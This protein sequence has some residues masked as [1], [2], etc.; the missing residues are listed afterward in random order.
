M[1]SILLTGLMA[2]FCGAAASLSAQVAG[3][4][5]EIEVLILENFE[6]GQM[7]FIREGGYVQ[8]ALW[9]DPKRK[10]KGALQHIEADRMVVNDVPVLFAECK[11]IKGKVRTDRDMGGGVLVGAGIT[12]A[13][14]GTVFIT[15]WEGRGV[16]AGGLTSLVVGMSMITGKRK[17]DFSKGWRA[18]GGKMEYRR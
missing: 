7:R 2:I 1:R 4:K 6:K 3:E 12:T 8:Y 14:M 10:I 15:S 13:A 17:F 11:Y 9:D 16:L 5:I 18:Y